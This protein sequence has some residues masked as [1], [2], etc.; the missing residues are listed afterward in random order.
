MKQVFKNRKTLYLVFGIV[1]VCVFSLTIV[2]AALNTVLKITGNADVVASNWD[3]HLDNVQVKSGSVGG[4]APKIISPTNATFSTKLTTPGDFYEFSIDIVNDG[5]ID[6]M[7]DN[8]IK[9][10]ELSSEQV[11]Y[12]NYV[13][14]YQS[15]ESISNKQLVKAGEFVRLV[16]RLEFRYD[17]S[18]SDLPKSPILLDLSFEVKYVQSDM[19]GSEVFNNG[20][21]L[22]EFNGDIDEIGTIVTIGTEKFYVYGIDGNNLKLLTVYNLYVGGDFDGVTCVP[23]GDEATG[24]QHPEM[25]GYISGQTIRKGVTVFSNAQQKG[26]NYSDY[27]GSIAEKYVNN[28]KNILEEYGIEIVEARLITYDE[29]KILGCIGASCKNAPSWILDNSYWTGTA[30]DNNNVYR[31]YSGDIFSSIVANQYHLGIRP[32]IVISKDYFV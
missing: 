32:V 2:Y 12:L 27:V 29:L 30:T 21:V 7:I 13:I 31:V 18:L 17:I 1:L 16:V 22:F 23:Y 25:R 6:A 4:V 5:T 24:R 19:S 9:L 3:I 20:M 28:Y 14:E 15:G 10:P 11:K 8:I 26:T